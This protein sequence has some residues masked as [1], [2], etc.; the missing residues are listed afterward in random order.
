MD[1][2]NNNIASIDVN[3]NTLLTSLVVWKN[4]LT[5]LHL[6]ANTALTYLDCEENQLTSLDLNNNIELSYLI[7]NNIVI[8]LLT[9]MNT[10]I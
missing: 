4:K 7:F 2:Y 1:C 6:D 8:L 3:K 5:N 9:P 10:F